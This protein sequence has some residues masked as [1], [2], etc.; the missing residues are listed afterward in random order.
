MPGSCRRERG[1]EGEQTGAGQTNGAR[2]CC[3]REPGPPAKNGKWRYVQQGRW[4]QPASYSPP[5]CD[6][7]RCQ[8][9][10]PGEQEMLRSRSWCSV[11]PEK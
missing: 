9:T 3:T 5:P 10:D 8:Y 11:D 6:I 4:Y 1:G 2:A 7:W